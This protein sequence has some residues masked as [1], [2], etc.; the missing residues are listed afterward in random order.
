MTVGN[1][2]VYVN[3]LHVHCVREC[4][5]H[6]LVYVNLVYTNL[7]YVNSVYVNLEYMNLVYV[8]FMTHNSPRNLAARSVRY[9]GCTMAERDCTCSAMLVSR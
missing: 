8:N 6:N 7:V 5:V 9:G 1:C 4:G 3:S 2:V